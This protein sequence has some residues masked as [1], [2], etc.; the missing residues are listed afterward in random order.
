MVSYVDKFA[1]NNAKQVHIAP[2]VEAAKR[3]NNPK[4][5]CTSVANSGGNVPP[6]TKCDAGR[7]P[8]SP[9]GCHVKSKEVAPKTPRSARWAPK[10]KI[11]AVE[12]LNTST[13]RTARPVADPKWNAASSCTPDPSPMGP[14]VLPMLRRNDPY[15]G[16]KSSQR[17]SKFNSAAVS[18]CVVAV[19]RARVSPDRDP[20][21]FP[22]NVGVR[23]R[24][25][26]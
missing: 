11:P 3:P 20:C 21:K 14:H 22:R 10:A 13:S 4:R 19:N 2:V 7:S 17:K 9:P 1:P 18:V 5:A 25:V 26:E 6:K 23:A 8:G 16:R 12:A 24:R 15:P